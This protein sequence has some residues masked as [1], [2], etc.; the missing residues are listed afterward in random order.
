MKVPRA[1]HHV[2]CFEYKEEAEEF[3]KA[4]KER[5]GQ[6]NLEIAEDKSKIIAFGRNAN[7]NDKGKPEVFDFLG[8]TH[9]CSKSRNGRFRV[10]RKTSRKKYKASL[11]KAKEWIR[12]NRH[13][14]KG[15]L[16]KKLN[17]KLQGYYNYY[18]IT[19]NMPM[20]SKYVDEIR[21]TLFKYLN[22]R[23]QRRSYEWDKFQLFMKKYP[24]ATPRLKVS[25][26][27][28]KTEIGYI[29]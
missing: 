20:L 9:Y 14:P 8:F 10:K 23:S 17:Q 5:L 2:F 7:N 3:Y 24:L 18:G 15:I 12:Y 26:F 21:R 25:I 27:E 29:M 6:F 11:I 16:I 1:T 19:D 28:L 13:L 22:K 4:L